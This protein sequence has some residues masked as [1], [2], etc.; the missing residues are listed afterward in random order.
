MIRYGQQRCKCFFFDAGVEK[1]LA[2][3]FKTLIARPDRDRK[4]MFVGL[5]FPEDFPCHRSTKATSQRV[6]SF[7]HGN[8]KTSDIKVYLR[9]IRSHSIFPPLAVDPPCCPTI[10]QDLYN[11]LVSSAHN[12]YDI[13]DICLCT[14]KASSGF[15]HLYAVHKV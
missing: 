10:R 12:G 3:P 8:K 4:G 7:V 9:S 5:T 14:F 6:S 2:S 1:H 15:H 13:I 11:A